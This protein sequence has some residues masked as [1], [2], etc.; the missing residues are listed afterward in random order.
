MNQSDQS[1]QGLYDP[2][3]EH[4]ACGTGFITNINGKKSHQIIQNALT[5]L[6]NMEHRGACGCDPDSGD[7]AG[8]LMQIPHEFFLE[9]CNELEIDLKEPGQYGVGMMFLPKDSLAKKAIRKIITDCAAQLN[10]PILGFRKV[11]VNSSVIGETARAVEPL[12][13]QLF[14]AKPEHVKDNDEFERKLYVLR[15][16]ITRTVSEEVK[17]SGDQF[18]FTSLSSRVIVYKGQLTTYQVRQYYSDLQDERFISGFGMVHSRFST[19]TFP[20]WKL[21]QPFRFIS[22]NG[23]I[24]TLTGNLNWFYSGVRSLVSPYFTQEEME[25]LLPVIDNNQSDSACLDNIVEV[26]THS[27]RSLPHVMMMLVP[28]AWDGNEAMDPLKKAFYEYHATL[29]E[30]WDGPA[31]LTFTDGKKLIGS[32]LDRNGLRPLRYVIT[33]DGTAIVASEAGVLTIDE[34]TVLRKG[35]LQPGKMFLIDIEDGKIITDEEIKAQIAGR[36]PY[37]RWLENYREL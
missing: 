19:N 20:S 26:L 25:I 13:K 14:V 12:V 4:D 6:E 28:E 21:A 35:R 22:H 24:N 11:P 8:I 23:E 36:Q 1:Q 33:S 17:T 31:A 5:I 30:P 34:S 29:M 10:I 9:E 3:F 32:I 7:G 2:K 16:L 15:R 18:Y 37:G 27:G